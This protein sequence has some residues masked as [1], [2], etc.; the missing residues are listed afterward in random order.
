[1]HPIGRD[2]VVQIGAEAAG[3][4]ERGGR[5]H[6]RDQLV[7]AHRV[8]DEQRA[9]LVL[10]D[11]D[12]DVAERRADHAPDQDGGEE[13]DERDQD[14]ERRLI[15]EIDAQ[16]VGPPDAAQAVLAAGERGPAVDDVEDHGGE[17]Q[18]EQREVDAAPAQDEEADDQAGERR[19]GDR[20]RDRQRNEPGARWIWNSAAA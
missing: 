3:E 19:E 9:L 1:M 11:R 6:E 4:A 18:G 13:H 5:E 14:V 15:V 12:Q 2:E 7:A 16:E 20:E 8:A 17:R 10:A